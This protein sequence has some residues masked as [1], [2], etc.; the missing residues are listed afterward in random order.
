MQWSYRNNPN[1]EYGVEIVPSKE[2]YESFP[3][4]YE[5]YGRII[6]NDFGFMELFSLMVIPFWIFVYKFFYLLILPLLP[7]SVVAFEL[8]REVV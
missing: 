1:M 4:K 5:V 6:N 2:N 3:V 7:I 8:V